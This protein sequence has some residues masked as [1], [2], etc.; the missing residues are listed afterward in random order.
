MTRTCLCAAE[1]NEARQLQ[2]AALI[3]DMSKALNA[4]Q[5]RNGSLTGELS[6]L[7]EKLYKAEADLAN[8]TA[9]LDHSRHL[10]DT[11]QQKFSSLQYV[12]LLQYC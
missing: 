1:L 7:R 2:Q 5:Q 3:A 6:T 12:V 11:E 4:E 8:T 10:L 9:Q